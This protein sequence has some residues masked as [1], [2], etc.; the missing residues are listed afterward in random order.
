L[1]SNREPATRLGKGAAAPRHRARSAPRTAPARRLPS[2]SAP[3]AAR[4]SPPPRPTTSLGYTP[5]E[6]AR[7]P[8]RTG[9]STAPRAARA[10]LRLDAS[11]FGPAVHPRSPTHVHRATAVSHAAVTPRPGQPYLTA[12]L[13]LSARHRAASPPL[14]P[15]VNLQ[16]R[17]LPPPADRLNLSPRTRRTS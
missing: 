6:A 8:R 2:A 12:A 10:V 5:A 11:P 7:A 16:R 17:S 15:P 1:G 4:R 9:V 14:P 13:S 3:L